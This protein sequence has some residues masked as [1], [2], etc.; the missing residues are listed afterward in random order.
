MGDAR[1]A[2]PECNSRRDVVDLA[3]LLRSQGFAYYRCRACGCWWKVPDGSDEP[4]S[5]TVIGIPYSFATSPK[6]KA[7]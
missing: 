1:T 2:C 7:G 3:D 6:A 5:R 4:T